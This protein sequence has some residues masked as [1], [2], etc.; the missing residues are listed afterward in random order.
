MDQAAILHAQANHDILV[1]VEEN[2]IMGGA[3]SAVNEFLNSQYINT[4]II[5][6]G[7]PDY[8]VEHGKPADMLKECGLD[9][10][11]I[12]RSIDKAREAFQTKATSTISAVS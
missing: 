3:G 1:T 4:P 8:Y 5:N 10:E 11:G 6:L 7:L 9:A 12:E 2:S